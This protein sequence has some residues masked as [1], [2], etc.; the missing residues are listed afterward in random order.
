MKNL[1]PYERFHFKNQSVLQ[2]LPED[3][4]RILRKN[5]RVIHFKK[6][7]TVFKE[8]TYPS[9]IFI[10]ESGSVK[11]KTLGQGGKEHIFYFSYQGE[12]L[13][14][15]SVLS[16]EPYCDTA[17]TL[18]PSDLIF[19]PKQDFLAAV[20]VSHKLSNH[21]LTNL[22]HEFGVFVNHTKILAQ[23]TVRERTALALV[24]LKGKKEI[25]AEGDSDLITLSRGDLANYIGTSKETLVRMLTD[26]KNE[27]LIR[28]IGNSIEIMDFQ[29]LISVSNYQ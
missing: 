10:I 22:S 17:I 13:G 11:K 5:E 9:G 26:F 2:D 12:M 19:I 20:E 7:E 8:G 3:V 4:N 29:G 1:F 18:E 14:Y 6:G 24:L 15:H 28:S 27:K 16:N 21:L 25:V 23:Y